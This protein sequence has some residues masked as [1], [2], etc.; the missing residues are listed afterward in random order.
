MENSELIEL[1]ILSAP[2]IHFFQDRLGEI[3]KTKLC[4]SFFL[5]V[6]KGPHSNFRNTYFISSS[7]E[8]SEKRKEKKRKLSEPFTRIEVRD[9]CMM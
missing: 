9:K 2:Y 4:D 5:Q 8:S 1:S 3:L 7:P 6:T